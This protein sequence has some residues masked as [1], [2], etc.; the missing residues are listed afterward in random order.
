MDKIISLE[1]ILLDYYDFFEL[2]YFPKPLNNLVSL[3]DVFLKGS[4]KKKKSY[5][6]SILSQM[7]LNNL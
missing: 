1:I 7:K 4:L 5:N 3:S 6:I 2:Y